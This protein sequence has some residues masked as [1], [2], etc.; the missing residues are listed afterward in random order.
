M[1]SLPEPPLSKPP[2]PEPPLSK[3]PLP[4]PPLSKPPLPEPPLSKPPLPE[5]PFPEPPVSKSVNKQSLETKIQALTLLI[6]NPGPRSNELYDR[7]YQITKIPPRTQRALLAKAAARGYDIVQ[8]KLISFAKIV[9]A[10]HGDVYVQED[11]ASSHAHKTQKEVY[12]I[13]EIKRLL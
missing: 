8:G 3:P 11:K 2:L 1:P 5:P 10:R 13:H 12:D 6:F 4:E 9:K 7:V